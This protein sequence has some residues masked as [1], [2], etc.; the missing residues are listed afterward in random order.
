MSDF[1]PIAIVGRSCLLPG[2]IV[3]PRG[4]W[5]AVAAGRDLVSN[6]PAGRWGIAKD[7]VLCADPS[8]SADRTWSD[9]GGYVSG[10]ASL[11]AELS[12]SEQA[13]DPLF[14]WVL[15]TARQALRDAS[16]SGS[17]Q[18][19]AGVFGNLSF[20]SSGLSRFAEGV[21]LG[22]VAAR[23]GVPK[24]DPRNRF[25]SG[26]PAAVLAK[27]LGLGG[28]AF[29]LDA[30]CASS[31]YAIERG[32]R[33][34]HDRRADLVVAGAVNRADDLF[35]HV[36]FC[37]L[38][39]LS[40]TG[41]SQPFS[42]RAD[43][44]LPGEGAGFA[45]LKRLTDAEAA[46]DRILGV[47][48]AIGLSN[49]G[50]GRGLLA[51][52][53]EGQARAMR[54]AYAEAGLDP[55]AVSLLEC[56][57]TGTP[58]GD[59]TEIAS[60]SEVFGRRALPIGSLKSNLGHL[61][62]AAGIAGLIK[63]L[64]AMEA[65][66]RPPTLHADPQSDAVRES[67]LRVLTAAEPWADDRRI[68]A[69]SAFGFG[70]NNAHL[71]VE[72]HR[73][74]SRPVDAAVRPV[75]IAVVALGAIAGGAADARA[76]AARLD[77]PAR[78]EST[79]GPIQLPLAGLRFPPK[80][81]EAALPQ[82]LAV[83]AAALD[84]VAQLGAPLPRDTTAVLIGLEADPEVAR[85]GARWRVAEWAK[86][87]GGDAAW[88]SRTRAGFVEVLQAAGVLG[89]M[90]NIPANRL[91]A[92]LDVAGPSYTLSA[93]ERSG[94]VA[95][96]IA[97]RDL[98]S[99]AIDAA[100]VGAVDF[101]AEPV[102]AAA[103]AA[104]GD[105]R[106]AGDAAVVLVLRRLADVSGERVLAVLDAPAAAPPG[107]VIG[108]GGVDP[109]RWFGTSYAASGLVQLA[110]AIAAVATGRRW[111]ADG[112]TAWN[113][114][115]RTCEASLTAFNG[116]L[117]TT[118]VS[119][120]GPPAALPAPPT[121][122]GP[123]LTRPSHPP[124]VTRPAAPTPRIQEIGMPRPPVLP[125]VFDDRPSA[126]SG[127]TGFVESDPPTSGP[128][129][130]SVPA[131][132]PMALPSPAALP[133]TPVGG[134]GFIHQVA[135]IHRA[136][137]EQQAA[138]H[139]RFLQ[140]RLNP[141]S[142]TAPPLPPPR[143]PAPVAPRVPEAPAP[144]PVAPPARSPAPAPAAATVAGPRSRPDTGAPL[145][146]PKIDRAGLE[147]LAGGRISQVFG[148]AFE[149][150]DAYV[151]QVRMPMPPLLLADRVTGI[152]AAAG[153]MGTGTLWTE[154]D[155]RQDS[156]YLF[157][158]VM[159]AGVMIESG[160]ADLLLISW[161]GVDWHNKGE[162]VYRLLGCDL[163]YQGGLPKAGDTLKYDI[164]VDGHANQGAI[165]LFFFHYDCRVDAKVRL[166]VRN[167][168][169]GFFTDQELRDSGGVLWD[170]AT[171]EIQADA[172]V[173]PPAVATTRTAFDAAQIEAFANGD[174]FTCFG[175]GFELAQTHVRT[176]R[177]SP[178]PMLFFDRIDEYA[179]RGGPW[180]RGYLRAQKTITPAEW[181]FEGHFK[182][183]PCMPGTLMFEGCLQAVGF[184]MTGLGYALKKDGWRFEVAPDL[185]Y[186]LRCRGQ[187]IPTSREL[188]TEIFVEEVHD[189]PIPTVYADFLCTVDGL[190][191]FHARRVAVR[192]VPDWP[193]SS[194]PEILS[195]YREPKPVAVVDGFPFGY[196][197][198][199]ACAWGRPSEAFGPMY[200]VFDQG[201]HCARLPGPPYHFMSRITRIDGPIGGMKVGTAIDLE[202]DIPERAW[203]FDENS[204]PVMPFAVLL[205]AALQ[206]CG[207][208]AC[209]IGSALT[210]EKDLYFRNLDGTGTLHRELLPTS[211]TLVTRA[212]LNNLSRSGGMIIVGFDVQC[213]LDGES[214]YDLK[215]VFGFFPTQAL[216]T[217]V[218][219]VPSDAEKTALEA[220]C[221]VLVDLQPRPPRYFGCPLSLPSPMLLM[222]DRIDGWWPAGGKKGLGKVRA[223]KDVEASEWFFKAHFFTDPVQPGSLGIEAMIQAVQ[224][225]AIE[226]GLDAG[227]VD[228]RFEG[229]ALEQPMS[230]K[231]R[232]QVLPRNKVVTA[233][234]DI[235]EIRRDAKGVLVVTDGWL[236]VDGL[237]IYGATGMGIRIVDAKNP[238]LHPPLSYDTITGLA[239]AAPAEERVR[240]DGWVRDHA[241]TWTLPALPA[242]S[243][244]QRLLTAVPGKASGLTDVT[245]YRWIVVHPEARLRTEVAGDQVKLFLGT[246]DRWDVAAT[247]T[248]H[249]EPLEFPAAEPVIAE[250]PMPDPYAAGSLF[251]GPALRYLTA[252]FEGDRCAA[253]TIDPSAGTAP[254]FEGQLDALTH[255][256]PH[257]DFHRWDPAIP[258]EM[259]AYPLK[260]P[261]L[262]LK[263]PPPA[264]P[265][266]AEA[267]YLGRRPEGPASRVTSPWVDFDLVEVLVP[268]GP[269]GS[270]DPG[271]RVAFL[272][273]RRPV[274]GLGL[275]TRDG[276]EFRVTAGDIKR[277]DWL[278]GTVAAVYG[279]A[280]PTRVA[281]AD[282]VAAAAGV[283]PGT[284]GFDGEIARSASQP[285]TRWPVQVGSGTARVTGS[286]SLDLG[287]VEAFWNR[288][289]GVGRWPVE[290][291]YY[292]LIRRFVRQVNVADPAAFQA[293]RGR[294]VL[295]LGN[296]QVGVESLLFSI[297][298][299][300]LT[301]VPTVTLAKAEHRAT[302][303]GTLIA[304][305]FSYPGVRDPGVITFFDRD[306][307]ASL[308]KIIGELAAEMS[309]PGKG[310]MVH[311]EGTRA[312]TCRTPV[313]KMS[314]AFLDLAIQVGAPVVPVRFVGG[315]PVEPIGSR[316]EFPV[317]MGQQDL[318]LGKPI[319]PE[320]LAGMGLKERKSAV[321][322]AINGLGP[323]NAAEEPFPGDPAFEARVAAWQAETGVSAEDAVLA[324][325][326]A[327]AVT[328][329]AE[330]RAI[331]GARIA[332][333]VG[334]WARALARRLTGAR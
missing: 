60:I 326:L 259:A 142:T 82:Q 329:T 238:R 265:Y 189:G 38:S 19:V 299:S 314:G 297:L 118:V 15:I 171:A 22:E 48:R 319:L 89:T 175:P 328:P 183:D 206:P 155:V 205:E 317:G 296:H 286:P 86:A 100:V 139:Q 313:E 50:R 140:I 153:S 25:M 235:V 109:A 98:A 230:W 269:I 216:A 219:I 214:V 166:S 37:A 16:H 310:V 84:A 270:A 315:L 213:L 285:L 164:H 156:W 81:L 28:G 119:A 144:P 288:W 105:R 275:S 263:G 226:L 302:W 229:L 124:P 42:R 203:Y 138:V 120:S 151:R 132:M 184:F 262:V 248:V 223:R 194:R 8:G 29:A 258:R 231:Y 267:R 185:P 268:K 26:M 67:G 128:I 5:D 161:L 305:N 281:V 196:A 290:D 318:W 110:A 135:A 87:L 72:P 99:G 61:I 31:L 224:W 287:A 129:A 32:C 149:R 56:H 121:V 117:S 233:E 198:L 131:P 304:Q 173:D 241:P 127:A 57:A 10:E 261:R 247:G 160:Q 236:W 190:K 181:T 54:R 204:N 65:G 159:P 210:T 200:T 62:T 225:A 6:A 283:H 180:K 152:D 123:R 298:A 202:Y 35:I 51:P 274:P 192:L 55:A 300:G 13:L 73:G 125:S 199:I 279:S 33:L 320:A 78:L 191:A 276:G 250:R 178:P 282:A 243:M 217:Q 266:R 187:V 77:A 211:G 309:G 34:L 18:R 162:R 201:R 75:P 122:S 147:V 239:R 145:P 179:V 114:E 68:A 134:E 273:D 222:I 272:R 251:H 1:E 264:T 306:D 278:P 53:V 102:H 327:D 4:L 308:P 172:R 23:A 90:P 182:N 113:E 186:A 227:M 141:P 112:G 148:P 188:V 242:M 234:M 11:V 316:L 9:R 154:T 257:D 107:L 207:W 158:G 21:W 293:I 20:P 168:Q 221:D 41:R 91:N 331:L 289:F 3:D 176:P 104:L 323:T 45:T 80:D 334:D 150:Q 303:L 39:A 74:R 167:G 43:G 136:F 277:S 137:V 130:G 106:P 215:T 101:S 69:V 252:L 249:F 232:G 271:D 253:G 295:Y 59:A 2:G 218:G 76:F 165:R 108:T 163:T 115:N 333:P 157:D 12:E 7:L 255:L 292:G 70:G 312:L 116:D 170:A 111:S 284:V 40:K 197:S 85:Y 95:L 52:S 71:I 195:D 330:T 58:V 208:I 27:A 66:I 307:K 324:C 47:I 49:D 301:G 93:G 325:V 83:M 126:R 36:G 228:P 174:A 256:L 291:L 332:P 103:S 44:L 143:P 322:E 193:L 254:A 169:A 245:V 294:S 96:D 237:R 88:I 92:Q 246:G 46:G 79:A 244:V 97:R 209:Y 64:G 63:V 24:S 280:D 220:D 17:N 311:V 321:I 30:A 133:S 14:Q 240:S 212:K 177:I 260:I 94:L 146:G